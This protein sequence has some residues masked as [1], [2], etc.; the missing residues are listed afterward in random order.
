MLLFSSETKCDEGHCS[1]LCQSVLRNVGFLQADAGLRTPFRSRWLSSTSVLRHL[2]FS[3]HPHCHG[4]TYFLVYTQERL[5]KDA[6]Q[7]HPHADGAGI[8]AMVTVERA[9]TNA[10]APIQQVRAI[11]ME[12]TSALAV[13]PAGQVDAA[14]VVVALD[15]ALCT[16]VDIWGQTCRYQNT[17]LGPSIAALSPFLSMLDARTTRFE[18]CTACSLITESH[19]VWNHPYTLCSAP[20]A[21]FC[22]GVQMLR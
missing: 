8:Q 11:V 12:T 7:R 18:C 22:R 16:L 2:V 17:K 14:G 21:P 19:T 9:L 10:G 1:L 6:R 20:C 13:V 3:V 4:I 15:Q 5:K